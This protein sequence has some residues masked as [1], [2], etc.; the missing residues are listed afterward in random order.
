MLLQ[1]ISMQEVEDAMAHLK[2]GKAPS[3]NGFTTNFFHVF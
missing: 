3:P 1:P 2:D